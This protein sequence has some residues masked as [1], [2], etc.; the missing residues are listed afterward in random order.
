MERLSFFLSTPPMLILG[1]CKYL[2]V[3]NLLR[4]G[5]KLHI[6]DGNFAPNVY[7]PTYDELKSANLEDKFIVFSVGVDFG[8][9]G[10]TV[11]YMNGYPMNLSE[12]PAHLFS[13]HPQYKAWTMGIPD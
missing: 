4:D 12:G 9:N 1:S 13:Y 11:I 5:I 6:K 8:T 7:L 2:K 10:T 3:S